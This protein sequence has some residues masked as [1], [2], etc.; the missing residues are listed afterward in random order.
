M[1]KSAKRGHV[2]PGDRSAVGEGMK[3]RLGHD[4]SE[5]ST[6]GPSNGP[7]GGGSPQAGRSGNEGSPTTRTGT[8]GTEG[9]PKH[10]TG[11]CGT[12]Q[13]GKEMGP[14]LEH[15][16]EADLPPLDWSIRGRRRGRETG[17]PPGQEHPGTQA[18]DWFIR[19]GMTRRR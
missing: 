16:G 5:R 12:E 10:R 11:A 18:Q 17:R 9:G 8:S 13:I 4:R 2:T 6:K 1:N 19:G 15:P 14:G 7:A 3:R